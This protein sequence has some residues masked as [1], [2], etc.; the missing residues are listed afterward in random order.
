M[1]HCANSNRITRT[2]LRIAAVV[3]LVWAAQVPSVSAQGQAY[4][5]QGGASSLFGGQ[6]GSVEVRGSN[7]TSRV[8][9][10]FLNGKP[11]YGIYYATAWRNVLWGAGDQVIP[12]TLPTDIFNSSYYFLGRGVSA[13]WKN[14]NNSFFVY[15]GATS[16]GFTTPFLNLAEARS[17]TA[18]IFYE[19]KL[20][21]SLRFFSRNVFAARQ[22]SLQSLQWSPDEHMRL[23]IS[24]GMGNNQRYWA[25]SLSLDKKW[26]EVDA[27]YSRAGDAFR[28]IRV[29]EP[30]NA[31]TDRENIRIALKPLRNLQFTLSRQNFLAPPQ[32]GVAGERAA[33]NSYSAWTSLHGLHIHGSYFDSATSSGR[34]RGLTTGARR[35]W[36]NRV[37]TG[38]DYMR[39][40]PSLGPA[41]HSIIATVR[42]RITPRLSF[43]QF[44]T[45]GSGQTYVSFGGN[46]LSNRFSAGI[47]Y[48]TIFLPFLTPGR[49][50]FKQVIA[51]NLRLRLW[52]GVELNAA[53]DV[54]PLGKVRYTTY[55]TGYAYRGGSFQQSSAAAGGAFYDFVVRGRVVEEGGQPVRGAAV[56]IDDDI[57]YT[58]S[59]GAFLQR[60]KKQ[61]D[62]NLSVALDQFILPGNYQVVS[63]PSTV[64]AA[65]EESAEL[66]EVVLKRLKNAGA[67]MLAEATPAR[68]FASGTNVQKAEVPELPSLQLS[69]RS[70]IDLIPAL[71]ARDMPVESAGLDSQRGGQL[72]N[73]KMSVGSFYLFPASGAAPIDLRPVQ[74]RYVAGS[75]QRGAARANSRKR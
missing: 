3:V 36:F 17:R 31:E 46:F 24:G 70:S 65:R 7:F 73:S 14:G 33:V 69:R 34:A 18:L 57:V 30:L 66:Y 62:G 35:N 25:G 5:F 39:S 43:S 71:M 61:K 16:A 20:T 2:A 22:T 41:F 27:S 11:R 51:I 72:H 38:V 45:T 19:R 9:F 55:A 64:K 54:T 75:S 29:D 37:D 63:A 15:G 42:E 40:Q 32:S 4:K 13:S 58:D 49:S 1:K 28:R 23:G 47:E 68:E 60:R 56:K 6:G 53:S 21:R 48:Q 12:F 52:G 74:V 8:G 67:T 10:G 59:Q 26:V 44:I 50:Q